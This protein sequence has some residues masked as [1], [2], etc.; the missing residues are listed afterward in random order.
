IPIIVFADRVAVPIQ[1][2]IEANAHPRDRRLDEEIVTKWGGNGED[3]LVV[4]N[5]IGVERRK[6]PSTSGTLILIN[7]RIAYEV[8]QIWIKILKKGMPQPRNLDPS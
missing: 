2:A 4:C 5:E 7:E 8:W 6:H 3:K 1:C